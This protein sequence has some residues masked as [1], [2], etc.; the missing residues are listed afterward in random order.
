MRFLK[1]I[2][3]YDRVVSSYPEVHKI[4]TKADGSYMVVAGID[5][6]ER[7]SS[8]HS[9]ADTNFSHSLSQSHASVILISHCVS[10]IFK[11]QFDV[12]N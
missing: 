12:I 3:V 11:E 8:R 6:S 4:E 2:F 5:S 9:H 10:N 1:A 7:P